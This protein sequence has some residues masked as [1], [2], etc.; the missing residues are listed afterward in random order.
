MLRISMCVVLLIVLRYLS[1]SLCFKS[2]KFYTF[3]AQQRMI[4]LAA[5]L[6]VDL[7]FSLYITNFIYWSDRYAAWLYSKGIFLCV[8]IKVNIH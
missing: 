4:E 5:T 3:L 7:F 6:V 1:E 8:Y 2:S